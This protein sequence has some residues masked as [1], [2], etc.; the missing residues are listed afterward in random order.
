MANLT[1]PSTSCKNVSLKTSAIFGLKLRLGDFE[2]ARLNLSG[3]FRICTFKI[4]YDY[5]TMQH[6]GLILRDKHAPF[7]ILYLANLMIMFE[8]WGTD[9]AVFCHNTFLPGICR[10]NP[11]LGLKASAV[12]PPG[13]TRRITREKFKTASDKQDEKELFDELKNRF[14][15]FKRNTYLEN[16]EHYQDLAKSQSPKFM[17]IAC[18]DSRVCPS[19][20][21][22]FQPGEAFMIRN[23][24]NLVPPFEHGPSETNAALEF[25]VNTLQVENIL[26]IGHSCCGGIQALMSMQDVSDDSSFIKSWVRVGR[27]ASISTKATASGLSFDQQCRHCEKESVIRSLSNLLTYPWIEERV[28]RETLSLHGGYYNF[29]DCTFEKWTVDYMAR[30]IKGNAAIKNQSFW[31]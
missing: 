7:C 9:T 12:E 15:S 18:A 10:I 24:A 14:L 21:L 6:S 23:V 17:V 8:Q 30:S 22:G 25:A 11:S 4:L 5:R 19:V 13:L 1:Q 20:I 27:N 28:M 29:I 3:S 26:V 2:Q 31:H 16:M